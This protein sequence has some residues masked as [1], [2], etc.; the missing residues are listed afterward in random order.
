MKWKK[1]NVMDLS[2]FPYLALRRRVP[3]WSNW[4]YVVDRSAKSWR[5][6]ALRGWHVALDHGCILCWWW[7]VPWNKRRVAL[8][9]SPL[10]INGVA[11]PWKRSERILCI[12]SEWRAR[13]LDCARPNVIKFVATNINEIYVPIP[14]DNPR[15][16]ELVRNPTEEKFVPKIFF[17]ITWIKSHPTF[18]ILF[19]EN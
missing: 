16:N 5:R 7:C 17:Y 11:S 1:K 10:R 15:E 18:V 14:R 13:S 9:G 3:S 8:E 4:L 12:I 6:I 19:F 2:W